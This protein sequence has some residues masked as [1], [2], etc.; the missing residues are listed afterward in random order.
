MSTVFYVFQYIFKYIVQLLCQPFS[1]KC[2]PFLYT[3][4]TKS[5]YTFLTKCQYIILHFYIL[6]IF[7]NTSCQ[8]NVNHYFNTCFNIFNC[9]PNIHNTPKKSTII[10]TSHTYFTLNTLNTSHNICQPFSFTYLNF[11]QHTQHLCHTLLFL[12]STRITRFAY[13]VNNLLPNTLLHVMRN[14]WYI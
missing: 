9:Y 3:F 10:Y 11:I 7:F 1:T 12:L 14:V 4:L 8:L 5:Q 6:F 13:V 2:Q